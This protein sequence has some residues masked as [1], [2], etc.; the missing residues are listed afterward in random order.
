MMSHY[1]WNLLNWFLCFPISQYIS[2]ISAWSHWNVLWVSCNMK[3]LL[4]YRDKKFG[5]SHVNKKRG[6]G[7]CGRYAWSPTSSHSLLQFPRRLPVCGH[8]PSPIVEVGLPRHSLSQTQ[9][10]Q[11]RGHVTQGWPMRPK[12]KFQED[13]RQRFSSMI[14][15][16]LHQLLHSFVLLSVCESAMLGVLAAVLYPRTENRKNFGGTNPGIWHHKTSK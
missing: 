11:G 16:E 1:L 7:S 6:G 13:F 9:R 4:T 12:G 3:E 5:L 2:S 15:R 14:K 8:G 10:Q